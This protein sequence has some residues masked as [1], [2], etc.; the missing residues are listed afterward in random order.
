MAKLA[1]GQ[2][3]GIPSIDDLKLDDIVREVR[4]TRRWSADTARKAELWYRR[5]LALSYR[6][7]RKPVFG[8]SK[9]ADH[10]WHAHIMSTARYREDC[11]R[12]FGGYLD[13]TP[14]RPANWKKRLDEAEE[15]Y[16]EAFGE[17]IPYSNICCY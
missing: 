2:R 6:H 1:A 12:I 17:I 10:L 4:R 5:F 3:T 15:E 9:L 13:H 14:G 8:I 11:E 16:R 7:D